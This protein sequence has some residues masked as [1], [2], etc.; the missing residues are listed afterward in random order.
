[1]GASV[2]EIRMPNHV[3]IAGAV[4]TGGQTINIPYAYADLRFNP[5][6]DKRT[7]YFYTLHSVRSDCK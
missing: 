6:F 3:G 5:A 1:M 7:G 4:F 2:G